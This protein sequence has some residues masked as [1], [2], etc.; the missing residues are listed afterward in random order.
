[1]S[2]APFVIITDNIREF[3]RVDGLKLENWI[4][5]EASDD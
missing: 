4:E 3:S 1:M 5:R 2:T